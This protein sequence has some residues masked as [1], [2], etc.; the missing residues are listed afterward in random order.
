MARPRTAELAGEKDRAAFSTLSEEELAEL[1]RFG[2]EQEAAKGDVLFRAGDVSYS[3]FAI[4]AGTVAIVHDYGGPTEHTLV[5][6]GAGH[7]LGEYNLLTGEPV[8]MTAVVREPARV[9]ALSPDQLREVIAQEPALSE[10]ILRTFLLRRGM[11]L[12]QG[13]GLRLVGSRFSPDSKRLLEFCSQN[14]LPHSFLDVEG[15]ETAEELLREFRVPPE[16]TPIAITGGEVL[17]NPSN[18]DLAAALGLAPRRRSTDVV[19][20]LVVG[21]GP[22][23]LAAAVYGATEGL[24]TL[25]VESVAVGGQAGAAPRIENYLGF[26][27]GI[28]GVELAARAAL[29]AKKFEAR[30]ST[31]AEAV[32][33]SAE[34]GLHVVRLSS[35]DE[36]V[37]RAIVIATGARYRR[38]DVER[39]EEFEGFGVYH[40]ASQ[41][42][43]R[44][45][46]DDEV[47]VVGGG[48][49]AGEAALALA[50]RTRRVHV[51]IRRDNLEPTMSR[52]LVEQVLRHPQIELSP[53]TRVRKLMGDG[54]LD[55][56]EVEDNRH[57]ARRQLGVRGLF[58][59]IGAEPHTQWLGG[60]LALDRAGYILT[61]R[62]AAPREGPPGVERLPLETSL[63]GVLAVGDVRS[64][65]VKRVASAVGEGSMAVRLLGEELDALPALTSGV[66]RLTLR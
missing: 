43:D 49:S 46:A 15:D 53:H 2:A 16:Q 26:P 61:G 50:M 28:S 3:F 27:A 41:G 17:R 12:G 14:R 24:T 30:I 45:S 20:L 60:Q 1:S 65:S 36:V 5:E 56:I 6:H 58:V 51:L 54:G 10:I 33:L 11:L 34:H 8:Y 38:L 9:V 42:E 63:P 59:L 4:L 37:A 48:N 18:A 55:G 21:A 19:D 64:G 40:L 35:G 22:G 29:Q 32:Q 44:L 23:G 47:A 7:F 13:F 57:G 52:Y 25:A 66:A 62:E 39:L 31:P